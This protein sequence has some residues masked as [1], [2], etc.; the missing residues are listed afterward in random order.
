MAKKIILGTDIARDAFKI[1]VNENFTE[2]Y[3]KD[4]ALGE[5]INSLVAGGTEYTAILQN[6]WTGI[7]KYRKNDLGQVSI[8]ANIYPGTTANGTLL[9]ALPA[10]Y[11]PISAVIAQHY[12]LSNGIIE[13]NI[14]IATDG[15]LYFMGN[16]AS[17]TGN[18]IQ[19]DALYSAI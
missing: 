3:D 17:T 4:V 16:T 5:Q 19:F 10:E 7:L 8:H 13:S 11:K 14:A 15:N 18:Q 1:K 6:G 9:T 12:N 2:L